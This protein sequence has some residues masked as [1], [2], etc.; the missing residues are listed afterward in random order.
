MRRSFVVA[1][2]AAACALLAPGVAWRAE[3]QN[4]STPSL[5]P[6]PA[7]Q[8]GLGGPSPFG[9]IASENFLV[10]SAANEHGSYLWVVAPVQHYVILCEKLEQAKDFS[11]MT[12]RLP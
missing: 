12:H 1:V 4:G 7:P 9:T 3:A 5:P 11:C 10:T 2:V 6:A 8:P